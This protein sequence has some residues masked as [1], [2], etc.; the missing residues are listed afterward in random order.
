MLVSFQYHY[1]WCLLACIRPL[2]VSICGGID[3]SYLLL[4]QKYIGTLAALVEIVAL[5]PVSHSP[6]SDTTSSADFLPRWPYRRTTAHIPI[7]FDDGVE[8]RAQTA[9]FICHSLVRKQKLCIILFHGWMITYYI[10]MKVIAHETDTYKLSLLTRA[11][12]SSNDKYE[13]IALAT[14]FL[15]SRNVS[16]PFV[17]PDRPVMM[18]ETLRNPSHWQMR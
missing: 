2:V 9:L 11:S 6:A 15:S 1:K 12:K 17:L 5:L 7:Q 4:Y 14:S 10:N 3:W 18:F 16:H 13:A 8:H